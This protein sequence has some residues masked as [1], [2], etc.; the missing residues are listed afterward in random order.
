MHSRIVACEGSQTILY[1]NIYLKLV[2]ATSNYVLI[3]RAQRARIDGEDDR[4]FR[5]KS[6]VCS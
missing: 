1:H 6:F 5:Q 2:V 4:V 3:T